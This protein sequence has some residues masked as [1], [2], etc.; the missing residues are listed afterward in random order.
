MGICSFYLKSINKCQNS[1]CYYEMY[2]DQTCPIKSEYTLEVGAVDPALKR[3]L[4]EEEK[5]TIE[6]ERAK[7]VVWGKNPK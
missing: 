5:R 2:P 3:K 6:K 1:Y 4:Q 7:V